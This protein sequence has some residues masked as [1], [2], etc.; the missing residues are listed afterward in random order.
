MS[1]HINET[2]V[3]GLASDFG[4]CLPNFESICA[5][6]SD[7]IISSRISICCALCAVRFALTCRF[8]IEFSDNG[9]VCTRGYFSAGHSVAR[10]HF[11]TNIILYFTIEISR[12]THITSENETKQ[13]TRKYRNSDRGNWR[14]KLEFQS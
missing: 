14:I 4:N 13:T 8:P 6:S 9:R 1:H 11:A 12:S 2:C 10:N 5:S 3:V 7:T